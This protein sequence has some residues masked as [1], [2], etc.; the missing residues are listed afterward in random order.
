[1]MMVA[2]AMA[3]VGYVV[4]PTAPPRFFPEWG[5]FDSVSAFAGVEPTPAPSTRLQPVRGD[6]L[7]ARRL[8]AHD[9]LV[10]GPAGRAPDSAAC[11]G[12]HIRSS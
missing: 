6:P 9:R 1:M 2:M 12:G 4:Y 7:D 10:A 3:L 11:G 8:R 5:F